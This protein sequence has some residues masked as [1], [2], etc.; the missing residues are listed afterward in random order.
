MQSRLGNECGA[1]PSALCHYCS[2]LQTGSD[3]EKDDAVGPSV[4]APPGPE[5]PFGVAGYVQ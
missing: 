3:R 5:R 1:V 2:L 4:T